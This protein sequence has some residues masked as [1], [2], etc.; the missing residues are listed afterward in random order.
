[1]LFKNHL[2]FFDKKWKWAASC[3]LL[4]GTVV[5]IYVIYVSIFWTCCSPPP[6]PTT[7]ITDDILN[8]PDLLYGNRTFIG[9][10]RTKSGSG[11]S[12][13]FNTYLYSSGKLIMESSELMMTPDGEKTIAYPTVQKELSK[14][15]MDGIINQIRDSGIMDKPC[16]AEMIFDL[17]I[18]YVINLDGAKKEIKFPGCESELKE[19][20]RLIDST[21]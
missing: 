4:L 7:I 12:C 10:C 20:D 11:G 5:F 15:L 9:F 21:K 2:K 14:G 13:R 17:Y 16:E 19:I 18:D 1:M 8:D 6:K 3:V